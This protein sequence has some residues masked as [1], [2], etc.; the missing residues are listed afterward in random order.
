M[1]KKNNNTGNKTPPALK[2][3]AGGRQALPKSVLSNEDNGQTARLLKKAITRSISKVHT[4]T[5]LQLNQSLSRAGIDIT[6]DMYL[7]LRALWEK[8]QRSQQELA[9]DV[10]KDKASLTKLVVN[11]EKRG[12]IYRTEGELDRRSKIVALTAEGR[13]LR[14]RVYPIVLDLIETLETG[15][16]TGQLAMMQQM[17]EKMYARLKR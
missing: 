12:L 5:R 14:H 6:P 2:T 10:F 15:F 11:L 16:S 9:D 3:A 1:E 8:D 13:A 7:I 4:A 17:L